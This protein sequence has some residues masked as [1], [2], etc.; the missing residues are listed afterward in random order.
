MLSFV[1][2]LVEL[3]T[4][5]NHTFEVISEKIQRILHYAVLILI[6]C[7]FLYFDHTFVSLL[8]EH[9]VLKQTM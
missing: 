8:F 2:K 4:K 1:Y 5:Y 6:N 9:S 7:C 3:K